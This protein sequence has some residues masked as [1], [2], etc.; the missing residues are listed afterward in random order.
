[1]L[2]HSIRKMR[3]CI[4]SSFY[5]LNDGISKRR[6]I[7]KYIEHISY[8]YNIGYDVIF[9][10]DISERLSNIYPNI[11][12]VNVLR[13][14]L[15]LW[16][17]IIS[18]DAERIEGGFDTTS[19]Q[20]SAITISKMY[21]I[22]E[23]KERFPDYT[24]YIWCDASLEGHGTIPYD[25]FKD[26]MNYSM[27]DKIR[28]VQMKYPEPWEREGNY[29]LTVNR[30]IIAASI[31]I[32]P[33]NLTLFFWNSTLDAVET[34]LTMK[35]LCLDE[36]VMAY[37]NGK[38]MDVFDY[39]FSDYAVLPNLKY[40]RREHNV[41]LRNMQIISNHDRHIACNIARLFLDSMEFM[42][43]FPK[44]IIP[45]I[46]YDIHRMSY[47]AQEEKHNGI[48]LHILTA[49]IIHYILYYRIHISFPYN[50]WDNIVFSGIVRDSIPEESNEIMKF[51]RMIH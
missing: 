10:T 41:I 2:Y 49:K 45:T 15:P 34:M 50:V 46:L 38:N 5:E 17:K 12:Y 21:F 44:D 18:S 16:N 20:Y 29:L 28:V 26:V 51:V 42:Y 9:F 30:G 40:I 24:H 36:Q 39:W 47:Y 31:F 1:M 4:V 14:E 35:C 7:M 19:K 8:L 6:K 32:V 11:Q 33:N 25:E 48:P 27:N 3:P 22:H 13:E 23:A 43:N 37:I